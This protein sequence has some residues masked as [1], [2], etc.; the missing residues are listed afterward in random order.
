MAFK[1]G[2][3]E[4][5]LKA[6][7]ANT[8]R[9]IDARGGKEKAPGYVKRLNEIDGAL[10]S[11]R[12]GAAPAA[13]GTGEPFNA[14]GYLE[15]N[16][17]V[18]REAE[19]LAAS[20]DPRTREQIAL[21]HWNSNGKA[22]GRTF[23]PTSTPPTTGSNDPAPLGDIPDKIENLPDAMETE[24]KV[25]DAETKGQIAYGNP[26][27]ETNPF[28]TKTTSFDENGRPVI[29]ETLSPQQQ[30]ILDQQQQLSQT[31][32]AA[33]QGIIE[34]GGLNK[35]FNPTLDER[36][37]QGDVQKFNEQQR[38]ELEA[39]LTRNFE[40]DK[41]RDLNTLETSLYNRGIPLDRQ[42]EA[43]DRAIEGLNRDYDSRRADAAAQALTFGGEEAQRIF[44]MNENIRKNQLDEQGKTRQQ[45]MAD[46]QT[47]ST[48][49]S[50]VILPEFSEFRGGTYDLRSPTEVQLGLN[51]SEE[52]KKTAETQRQLLRAQ[53][54]A[55][56]RQGTGGGSRGNTG[57]VAQSPFVDA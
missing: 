18:A 32:G 16:P 35:A 55:A 29:T 56:K 26:S 4:A 3:T 10:R 20:G 37:T 53:Q 21:D 6:Q 41:A 2:T 50:G 45:N 40:R 36:V 33:A 22:E 48:L 17:D 54:E 23:A 27:Q 5:E 12:S 8:L 19:R 43:Y 24:K 38:Q 47:L 30:A 14:K 15:A 46:T 57:T 28:G 42:A 34:T 13:G 25:A 11:I 44:D 51:A 9:E 39:Y 1:L 31:G 7:R 49:G 52:A